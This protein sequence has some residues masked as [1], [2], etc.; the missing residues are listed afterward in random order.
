LLFGEVGFDCNQILGADFKVDLTQ[1]VVAEL[2]L[3]ILTHAERLIN[4]Q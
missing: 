2:E 3:A 1:N 4:H